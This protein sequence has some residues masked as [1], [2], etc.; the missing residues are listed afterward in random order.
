MGGIPL[1]VR[2]GGAR[3]E[4]HNQNEVPLPTERERKTRPQFCGLQASK[5][6]PSARRRG[7]G[8]GVWSS[9]EGGGAPC[10]LAISA[11]E[12]TDVGRAETSWEKAR[13]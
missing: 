6:K 5:G 1:V 13:V 2:D 4:E 11:R 3:K 9:N 8:Q 10:T 12:K 7:G